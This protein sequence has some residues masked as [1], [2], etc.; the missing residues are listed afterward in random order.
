MCTW[1]LQKLCYYSQAWSLAWT[2]TPLFEEDFVAWK[3]GPV[4]RELFFAL[5]GRFTVSEDDLPNGDFS[6][7]SSDQKET[8][9]IVVGDYVAMAPFE[10]RELSHTEAPWLDAREGLNDDED[11]NNV[12]SKSSMGEYYGSL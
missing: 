10:L 7:L 8:I 2:E 11:C 3:N 12:I 9:D 1:K 4:C 5:K 6:R